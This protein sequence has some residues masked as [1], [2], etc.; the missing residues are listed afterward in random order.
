MSSDMTYYEQLGVDENASTDEINGAFY[1]KVREHPPEQ[2]SEAYGRI[3]EAYDV[4]SNPVARREY[5]SM[6]QHGDKIK[7]LEKEADALLHEDPPDAEAA[8]RKLRKAVVLGP[9]IGLL[10]DMLGNAYMVDDAYED[11]LA[12]YERAAS[13]DPDNSS[14]QLHQGYAYH[15]LGRLADAEEI[16]RAVWEED[17]GDYE[18]AR[19]LATVLFE[20]DKVNKAHDV[21]DTAI[22]DDGKV[23][24]ED[25]FCYYDKLHF[26]LH[27]NDRS[28]LRS[29]LETV[30]D[31]PQTQ[32]DRLFAAFML[33]RVGSQLYDVGGHEVADQFLEAARELDPDN[34]NLAALADANTTL[35]TL[36]KQ[37]DATLDLQDAP[38]VLKQVVAL[39]WNRVIGEIDQDTYESGIEE[40]AHFLDE[41]MFTDPMCANAKK[42]ARRIRNRYDAVYDLNPGL[43]DAIIDAPRATH[44]SKECPYC[45]AFITAHKQNDRGRGHCRTCGNAIRFDGSD[46]NKAGS[47]SSTS[48]TPPSSSGAGS[49][50]GGGGCFVATAVY[51]TY[52]HPDV[53]TLRAYRDGTLRHSA[54]GRC[55]IRWYYRYG[56][57]LANRLEN[58]PRVRRGIRQGLRILVR[59]LKR[60]GR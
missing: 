27:K 8:I 4:L 31:L 17:R 33:G 40:A 18:P 35:V 55:F 49:G 23:D 13:I 37:V 48:H 6:A 38:D 56:P 11:A 54:V 60:T 29:T 26:F 24:F 52:D 22:A 41:T 42:T 30:K 53:R 12:Q 44:V 2:D 59:F 46:F 50:S 14:Y 39:G 25:F 15:R 51:G 32:D 28:G 9:E 10:R 34:E 47:S 20:Q 58:V 3:R 1:K 5:D 57:G 45:D 16:F 19:A 43:Y 36:E 7:A 21:L